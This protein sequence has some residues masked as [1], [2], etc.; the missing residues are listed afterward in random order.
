MLKQRIPE[1]VEKQ[2]PIDMLE[3]G[4]FQPRQDFDP[5]ALQELA[6]SIA[7]VGIIQALLVRPRQ[8]QRYEIIAGERR[9]RAAQLAGLTTI[10]C[11]VGYFDDEQAAQLAIIEN[12]ERQDLNP[13]ELAQSI[14]RLAQEF[15][16]TH[17]KI[18]ELLSK[19]RTEIT[20]LLRLL[21]LDD[22]IQ[23]FMIEGKLTESHGKALAGLPNEQQYQFANLAVAK[24]LSTRALEKIIKSS[25]SLSKSNKNSI[26]ED[27]NLKRLEQRLSDYL[28]NTVNIRLEEKQKG[29]L[30]I[31]FHSLDELE[32]IF[33]RIGYH[34]DV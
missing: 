19:S 15:D 2:L 11:R 1:V 17:E 26:I 31:Q 29:H 32:G 10:P 30:M 21:K 24:C 12:L 34:H 20:N 13:I 25:T 6:N 33:D 23:K 9:W 3:R 8:N 18:A 7:Q 14:S 27:P 5:H 28:G 16:Y 4:Q 22:R